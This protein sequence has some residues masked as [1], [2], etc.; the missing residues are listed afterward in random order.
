MTEMFIRSKNEHG[1]LYV[2][3]IGDGDNKT[4][5]DILNINPCENEASVK[6][7]CMGHVEKR[8]GTRLR[9]MKKVTQVS[10]VKM[11]GN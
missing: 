3:Y 7:E 8:M 1:I 6:K 4:F 2:N 9:N 11:L 10:A 5:K